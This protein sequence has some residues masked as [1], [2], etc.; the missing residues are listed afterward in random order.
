MILKTLYLSLMQK[1]ELNR[2]DLLALQ[3]THLANERT[4]L[5]WFR[6]FVV[7]LSSGFAIV[8]MAALEEI[9]P[10]GFA[11]LIASPV[12]LFFGI[13]RFYYV[14]KQLRKYYTN[15]FQDAVEQ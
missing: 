14:K 11:L 3:R 4:L 7:M 6:T 12:L 1:L 15:D 10:L 5:A 9:L 13:L 8:K 2:T